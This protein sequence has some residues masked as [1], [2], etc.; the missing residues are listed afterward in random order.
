VVRPSRASIAPYLVDEGLKPV[1]RLGWLLPLIIANLP[2]SPSTNS[3][4]V[5]MVTS[6]P[7]CEILRV[8][9]ICLALSKLLTLW[10][11]SLHNEANNTVVACA[12]L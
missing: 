11:L 6:F 4:L 2:S 9:Q 1:V 7:S 5:S 3:I 12:F 10:Y 8:S